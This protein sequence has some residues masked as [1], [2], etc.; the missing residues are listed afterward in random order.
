MRDTVLSNINVLARNMG[1]SLGEVINRYFLFTMNGVII[2]EDDAI[3]F[4]LGDG[5]VIINGEV[6]VLDPGPKN[7]P[8]YMAYQLTGSSVTDG[9][10]SSLEFQTVRKMPTA[11]L[12]TFLVGTDGIKDV[13]D[14]QERNLPGQSEPVGPISQ[15]WQQDKYF[16]PGTVAVTRRL[17]LMAR[18]WPRQGTNGRYV[19][20]GGLLADDTTL[21][22]GRRKTTDK[23]QGE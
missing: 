18:D 11:E 10:P 8:V 19:L 20:D 7:Q 9:D 22:V 3:F 15:F 5:V 16:V 14:R 6:T 4:A 13:I 12:Q 23:I 21:I 1:V 17:N 2:T